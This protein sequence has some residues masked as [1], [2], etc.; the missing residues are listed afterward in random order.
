M[1][2]L[3]LRFEENRGQWDA[4]VRFTARSNGVN[5]Q[6]TD[7]GP[8]FLVGSSRVQIDLVHASASPESSSRSKSCRPPPTIWW[9]PQPVAY[10]SRQ[11]RPRALPSVYPGIDVVYYGNRNQLEYDFVLAPGANPDA[12]RLNFR[13]DVKVSLTPGGDLALDG[14]GCRDSAEGARDLPGRPP[15]QRALHPAA[16]TR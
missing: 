1:A 2:G 10:R 15:D 4:S 7:R 5:L 3:P 8:A 16:A 12:I 14:H 6:L 11:L 13:G 9:A